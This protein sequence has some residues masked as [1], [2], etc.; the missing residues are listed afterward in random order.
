[1]IDITN[2]IKFLVDNWSKV[3]DKFKETVKTNPEEEVIML[4]DRQ[5]PSV[6]QSWD[7]DEERI[8]VN[9][10]GR[11]IW[12]FDS[13]CSCPAPWYDSAPDCYNSDEGWKE[14]ELNIEQFDHGAVEECLEVINSIKTELNV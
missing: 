6:E 12:G 10:F 5:K 9:R 11:V 13:G 2:E 8:S 4:L 14:F 7:F 1:M 3:P